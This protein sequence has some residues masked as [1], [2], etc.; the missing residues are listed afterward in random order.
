MVFF[1]KASVSI[2]GK[3]ILDFKTESLLLLKIQG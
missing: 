2:P 1:K 3:Q